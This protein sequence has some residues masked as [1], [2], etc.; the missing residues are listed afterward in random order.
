MINPWQGVNN[1][2]SLG[3]HIGDDAIPIPTVSIS[4]LISWSDTLSQFFCCPSLLF[5]AFQLPAFQNYH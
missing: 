2:A 5:F 3:V 4:Q 1:E